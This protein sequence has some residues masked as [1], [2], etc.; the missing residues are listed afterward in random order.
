MNK[1]IR[2]IVLTIGGAAIAFSVSAQEQK[3]QSLDQLLQFVRQGQS[4]DARE[5]RER[6]A[7]FAKD[8]ASQAAELNSARGQRTAQQNRSVELENAFEANE[9]LI[10]QKQAILRER[11]GSLSELFGHVTS[12]AGDARANFQ[13]SLT[14]VD[15]G[16]DRIAT[17]DR[18]IELASS[19]EDLPSIADLEGFWFELQ[20]EMNESG[21][22][23]KFPATIVKPDGSQEEAQVVRVGVF[24]VVSDSGRY[25]RFEPSTGAL[26]ELP[27][28]PAGK[29]V[30]AAADLASA[31]GGVQPFG[32]DPTGPS[33][34]TLLAALIAAPTLIERWHQGQQV[35]YVITALGIFGFLLAIM[36]L[37]QLTV[38]DAKV[39][40]QLKSD[41]ARSDNPLGRVLAVHENNPGMDIET[42]ELKLSEAV[43]REL[44]KIESG[45]T[46]LKIISTVAPLL[47]LLGTVTGMILTF[48]AITIFGA[49]DPKAMAGGIS[50]A[51]IT[52]VLG[53][54]VAIP[55]VLLHTFVS[56]RAKKI[57]Q[58]LEE[59][60][61]GIIAEHTE[62]SLRKG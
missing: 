28:Q 50:A 7:R 21:A 19:G 5:A 12:A 9:L 20:Q 18:L 17:L 53:L 40:A 30:S 3:A 45:L 13:T 29:F 10:S 56:G 6:E 61:T 47:G 22:V 57:I 33:G 52:T 48:Q 31:S 39:S 25:L 44:P 43:L 37:V 55:V 54:I 4:T 59:E 24:N 14:S 23:R 32:I 1:L 62:S 46:L 2:N 8:K 49:G 51:L 42:L 34:G 38:M 11:L 27:R 41:K 16:S 60:T 26:S 35:G 58:I 15:L 36:R